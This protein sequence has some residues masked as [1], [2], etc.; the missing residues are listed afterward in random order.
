[1]ITGVDFVRSLAHPP[2]VIFTTAYRDY[3]VDAFELNVVDYLLKPISLERFTKAINHFLEETNQKNKSGNLED[4]SNSRDYIFLKADKKHYK[5]NLSD[6]L[7]FESLGDYV[8]A[9][10]TTKKIIT[11]ER[12]SHLH[13]K[14]PTNHFIQIHRGFIVSIDKIE[15]V[16]PG[17]VEINKKKLPVGRNYKPQLNDLMEKN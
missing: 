15:S 7:Y 2:K 3:A 9:F 4:K 16:G 8:I 17:F 6:I 14:L 12:I 11:K 10:T 13:E 1:Q 5:I